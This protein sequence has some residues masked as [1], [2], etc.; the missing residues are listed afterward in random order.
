MNY[1]VL[2]KEEPDFIRC[3]SEQ[4]ALKIATQYQTIVNCIV[5]SDTLITLQVPEMRMGFAPKV[6]EDDIRDMMGEDNYKNLVETT[7]LSM[8]ESK[9]I[10]DGSSDK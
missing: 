10:E 7:N 9:R 4:E 2:L 3:S 5:S 8:I 1:I 6:Q